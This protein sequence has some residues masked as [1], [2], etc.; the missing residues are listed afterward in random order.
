[1]SWTEQD[2]ATLRAA[3]A[4]GTLSVRFEDGRMV[5]YPNAADLLSRIQTVEASLAQQTS[6]KPRA[7][8]RL[9]TFSRD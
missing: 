9:T 3:Y 2:L 5:T 6:G 7:M 8:T 4:S 1:M